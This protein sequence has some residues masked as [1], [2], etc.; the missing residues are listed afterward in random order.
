MKRKLFFIGCW[1][2]TLFTQAFSQEN[3]SGLSLNGYV[4]GSVY[5]ANESYDISTGFAELDL[6][7]RF[8]KGRAFMLG[9]IRLREGTFFNQHEQQLEVTELYAGFRGEWFDLLLGNQVVKWGRTDGF[10]P[11]NNITPNDYFFLSGEPDD[12]SMSNFMLRAKIRPTKNM[13]LD[14]IAIPRY[15]ASVYRYDLFNMGDNVSFSPALYPEPLIENGS[16]AARLN[17]VTMVGGLALSVFNGYDPYHGFDVEAIDWSTGTPV[18]TN[19]AKVYR[20]TS[21]GLDFD[22]PIGSMIVRGEGAYNITDNP[23]NNM[24]TPLSD[25]SYVAG[26]EMNIGGV[27]TIAQY[28]GKFTPDFNALPAPVLSDPMNPMAQMQYANEMIQYESRM[29]NRRIFHQQEKINHALSLTLMKSF[30]YD[31]WTVD[32]SGYYNLTSGEWLVRPRLAWKVSDALTASIG[33]NYM[34]GDG[35]TLFAYSSEVMNGAFLEMK[36]SF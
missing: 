17:M 35:A 24:Y 31:S 30:G 18:I 6:T 23:E 32:V 13:E 12:Q 8:D 33:A 10:N 19:R 34:W 26:V 4:R 21:I 27:I 36:V 3:S 14:L 11:T 1:C 20:K 7:A 9:E 16:V 22:L 5:G 28:I 15:R 29:F 25:F 2:L